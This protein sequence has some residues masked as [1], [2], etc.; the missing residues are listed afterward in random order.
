MGTFSVASHDNVVAFKEWLLAAA[1]G[2]KP[3]IFKTFRKIC[4]S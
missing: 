3:N 2:E 1:F 4:V